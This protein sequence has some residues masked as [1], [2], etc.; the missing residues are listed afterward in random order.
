MGEACGTYEGEKC[1]NQKGK[2]D[3]KNLSTDGR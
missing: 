3:L 1:K 2:K